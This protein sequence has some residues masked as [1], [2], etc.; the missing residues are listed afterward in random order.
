[1]MIMILLELILNAFHD[2][3]K[4]G[5]YSNVA[6]SNKCLSQTV[7]LKK[8]CFFEHLLHCKVIVQQQ[9]QQQQQQ[10]Q[11]TTHHILDPKELNPIVLF[12]L[13]IIFN[14]VKM[15]IVHCHFG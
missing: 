15:P 7:D 3:E 12:H 10:H 11:K 9:Q 14:A 4:Q 2:L 6:S 1:M 8:V 13:K 5:K